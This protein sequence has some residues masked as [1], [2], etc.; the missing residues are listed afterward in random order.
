MWT[1]GSVIVGVGAILFSCG[2]AQYKA[3]FWGKK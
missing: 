2:V 1:G 3:G